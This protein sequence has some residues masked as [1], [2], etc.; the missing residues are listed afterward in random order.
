MKTHIEII[1][2]SHHSEYENEK[3]K[4]NVIETIG[5]KNF[6]INIIENYNE[7]SLS[8]IYN[9]FLD[10]EHDNS[11]I[12]IFCHSDIIFKTKNW[13]LKLLKHFNNSDYGIIGV[14]GTKTLSNSGVWWE[15]PKSMCGI[16]EHTDGSKVWKNAYSDE[17]KGIESVVVIDGVFMSVDPNKIKTNFFENYGMFHFYDIPFSL[18]NH[19][20][21]VNVG[22]ITDI[23]LLH[24]SI[25]RTNKE[26]EESKE[27]F[28]K[29]FK[30]QLPAHTLPK[31]DVINIK[32]LKKTPKVSIIILT[33]NNLEILVNSLK[34]WNK[35][36][37]YEN[38]EIIIA[39]TGSDDEIKKAYKNIFHQDIKI[40][41][42]DYYSFT[43]INNDVVKNHVSEDSELILF[44]NDDVFILNDALTLSV[45]YY[46]KNI[47]NIGT[48]G[49]RLHYEDSSIQHCGIIVKRF[50]NNKDYIITHRN[51]GD[52]IFSC[53]DNISSIGNT[54]AFLLINK[55]LFNSIGGFNE[56]YIECFEDVEL[57]LNCILRKKQNKTLCNAVAYHIESVTRNKSINKN[58][59]TSMDY[60]LNLKPFI[61]NNESKLKKYIK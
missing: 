50:N 24:K 23:R 61:V 39:D 16:V 37:T 26:W 27:K 56:N 3:F 55:D 45:D 12:L 47:K 52:F 31:I 33:K 11:T 28:L 59:N 49:I 60:N 35:F 10:K 13:G 46:N 7:K 40:I 51:L 14:A 36:N 18:S 8:R 54:G 43:K 48:V 22:V 42:Y 9:D 34:H 29:D 6:N 2:S 41:E 20:L 32:E 19:I 58:K 25:G 1:S 5:I 44:C 4:T 15:N 53:E 21:G 17:I 57:N 30:D 38:I